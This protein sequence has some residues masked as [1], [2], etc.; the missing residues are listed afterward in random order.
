MSRAT[1]SAGAFFGGAGKRI[2]TPHEHDVLLGRGGGINSHEGNVQFRAWVAERKNDYNL[3]PSKTE[4][5]RA[6]REVMALV[7]NRFPPGRFLKRDPTCMEWW[8][9]I[10]DEKMMT[11]TSQALREGAP[12]IRAL[13][14]DELQEIR[15]KKSTVRR[16]RKPSPERTLGFVQPEHTAPTLL[17]KPAM[18]A[19]RAI[20]HEARDSAAEEPVEEDVFER[21]EKRVRLDYSRQRVLTTDETPP[22]MPL[23]SPD[24]VVPLDQTLMPKPAVMRTGQGRWNARERIN[25]GWTK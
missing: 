17:G 5:A 23:L 6:A 11:K 19:L 21:P 20:M 2:R 16:P 1:Y 18:T 14:K 9:E 12:Q 4:K 22:L 15:A 25:S 8:V 7:Q 13:H 3:A 24:Y 10:D